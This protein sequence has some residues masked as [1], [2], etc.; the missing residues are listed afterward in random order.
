M[1]PHWHDLLK[2]TPFLVGQF[3]F[4]FGSLAATLEGYFAAF[5][6]FLLQIVVFIWNVLVYVAQYIWTALNFIGN[7]FYQL[8]LDV[9][10]AFKW[11]WENVIK[12]GLT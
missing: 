5:L 1:K 12:A 2:L 8:A 9:G 11:I 7:F 6:N 4:D 10:K 3:G